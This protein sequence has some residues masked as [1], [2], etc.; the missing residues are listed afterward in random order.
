MRQLFNCT[1]ITV[2]LSVICAAPLLAAKI[3]HQGTVYTD[4]AG[5]SLKFPEGVACG[6]DS[7]VVADTGNSQVAR[8]TLGNQSITAAA[9]FPLP[10]SAPLVAQ[11]SND[12]DIYILDGKSRQIIH[13]D[14][15]GQV[16]GKIEPKGLPGSKTVMTRSFRL[17]GDELYLL[18]IHT[19]RV[20]I[21]DK[22]GTY[23]KHIKFPD[24]Y[25]FFSDL[26]ISQQGSVYLLDSVAGAI[27]RANA[28]GD[29]F[30][31][32][33]SGL[34]EYLNFPTSLAI[35]GKGDIY[36]S[37]QYGSGLV[38]IGRDGSFQGRKF[39]MGWEDGQLLYPSQICINPQGTLVI[40]DRSNSRVQVFNILEE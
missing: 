7:F 39:G 26:A 10:D 1:I 24:G 38:V 6:N 18:D 3:K 11:L 33:S 21:L 28:S 12:G 36:L 9:V 30:N 16:K 20:L 32:F 25:R 22:K 19:E 8:Y 5:L 27:Y 40:A 13:M 35:D 4:S 29:E 23:Q 17:V 37:D 14:S 15:S 2:L 31:V 34:K